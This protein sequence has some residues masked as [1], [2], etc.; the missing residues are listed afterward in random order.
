MFVPDR[1]A[2]AELCRRFHVRHLVLFGSA[3]SDRFDA[4]HSDVDFLVEFE[5][6]PFDRFDAFFGRKEELESL[7]GLPVDLVTPSA[8]ENPYFAASVARNAEEL[9]AA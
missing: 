9:Y 1:A 4:S 2:I 7:L 6:G 5:D 3:T 8:L